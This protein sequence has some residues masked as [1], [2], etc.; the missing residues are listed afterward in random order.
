MKK[1]SLVLAAGLV[2]CAHG[3]Q[4]TSS[5]STQFVTKSTPILFA[6][7]I[8]PALA[9]WEKLGFKR[10]SE[11][12]AG[13][14]L[15][16]AIVSNGSIELMY[17]TVEAVAQEAQPTREAAPSSKAFLY[18]EVPSLAA[19]KKALADVPVYVPERKMFYGATE[20]SYRDPAGHFVTFAELEKK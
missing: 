17:Q 6:E 9:F 16:F 11:V 15:A 4:E 12:P 19:V 14:H 5:M 18:V 13:D 1:I 7:R 3:A 20:I 8:E 2:A 10:E